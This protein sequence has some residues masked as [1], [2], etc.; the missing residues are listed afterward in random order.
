MIIVDVPSVSR[1]RLTV[2]VLDSTI[3]SVTALVVG[4][5]GAATITF[6]HEG[7]AA[8]GAATGASVGAFVGATAA[9]A[10]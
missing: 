5:T 10:T 6:G 3:R 2:A 4:A 9:T 1:L 7:T 8:T